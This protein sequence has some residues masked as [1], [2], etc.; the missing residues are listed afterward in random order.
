MNSYLLNTVPHWLMFCFLPI[1][2]AKWN[3][4]CG[5]EKSICRFT[6]F[7]M[8]FS[9]QSKFASLLFCNS[10]I[11]RFTQSMV[12]PSWANLTKGFSLSSSNSEKKWFHLK[13]CT[14]FTVLQCVKMKNLLSPTR[15]KISSNQLFSNFISKTVTFT[16]FFSK[17]FESKFP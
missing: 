12:S 3:W 10:Q 15:K 13:S 1:S 16:K 8:I 14:Y 2:A 7:L 6:K 11:R 5:T 17:T 4:A 9:S